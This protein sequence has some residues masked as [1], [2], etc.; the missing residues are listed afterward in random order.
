MKKMIPFLAAAILFTLTTTALAQQ[1]P[2]ITASLNKDQARPLLSVATK[3]QDSLNLSEK[4]RAAI[5][6]WISDTALHM[7][8][9]LSKKMTLEKSIQRKALKGDDKKAVMSKM[10]RANRLREEI[11]SRQLDCRD[12]L[13]NI[14]DKKQWGKLVKL[15]T[16]ETK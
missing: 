10:Q 9:L 12:N 3:N 16:T 13:H 11:I 1:A 6:L 8:V 15:Y 5:G 7:R 14:L 4:Q 2:K